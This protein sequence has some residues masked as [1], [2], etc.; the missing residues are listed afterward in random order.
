[1]RNTTRAAAIAGVALAATA[2]AAGPAAASGSH[3]T[4]DG[5]V[6]VQTNGTDGNKI[7]SYDRNLH[8]V[9]TYATGGLGTPATTAVDPLASQGGLTLDRAHGLLYAVN[10]ASNSVTVFGVHGARLTRLQVIG[11]GGSFPVGV[12]VH[13]QTVYVLNAHDGGSIQGFRRYG[14]RLVAL[15]GSHRKLGLTAA[16]DSPGQVAF[17]PDGR[18]L[19]VTIKGASEIDVFAVTA[20]GGVSAQPVRHQT[21]GKTPFALDF[22]RFGHAVV[23]EAG[24]NAAATFDLRR[25]GRLVPLAEVAT[26]GKATC[27][28]TGVNGTFYLS[29]AATGTISAFRTRADGSLAN[30]GT[31]HTAGGGTIDTAASSDGRTLYAETGATPDGIEAFRIGHDGRLTAAGSA[32]IPGG[33]NS[34]GIAAY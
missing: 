9:G 8:Q 21:P 29:N 23:A 33:V 24:T 16:N 15:P 27:W 14:D 28:V 11:S 18:H 19:L 25:D 20:S 31:T 5:A 30:L 17:S 7:V 3:H 32:S 34:E 6:F 22:D 1:M 13:G 26:G 12:A 2:T 4:P 10:A